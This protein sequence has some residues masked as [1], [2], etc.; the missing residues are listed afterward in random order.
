MT[1]IW[2]VCLGF[3]Y[4]TSVYHTPVYLLSAIMD[5][6]VHIR[7]NPACV[8]PV[9]RALF[10]MRKALDAWSN[11]NDEEQRLNEV[12][13]SLDELVQR[14]NSN[15]AVLEKQASNR[16]RLEAAKD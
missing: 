2:G 7:R 11:A 16:L 3:V 15:P 14:T 10:S 9:I 8:V 6:L 5:G 4:L 13:E 12:Q 1:V